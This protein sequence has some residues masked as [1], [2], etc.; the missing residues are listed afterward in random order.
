[1]YS[2]AFARNS[3]ATGGMQYRSPQ[4]YGRANEGNGIRGEPEN[5]LKP[6]K[7]G[8]LTIG[9]L[10]NVLGFD[11]TPPD[12]IARAAAGNRQ[13]YSDPDATLG[14]GSGLRHGDFMKAVALTAL[15]DS[16]FLTTRSNTFTVYVSVMD[17]ENPQASVRS[18]LTVDRANLLPRLVRSGGYTTTIQS[19]SLPA[20]IA[21]RRMGFYNARYDD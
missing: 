14:D 7:F 11:S 3:V 8:F 13:L 18:Q 4:L 12:A 20:V 17:R 10:V 15:L 6:T 19:H 2:T 5:S 1:M 16:H 21:E 9:E